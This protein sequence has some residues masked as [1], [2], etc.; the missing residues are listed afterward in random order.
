LLFFCFFLAIPLASANPISI[1]VEGQHF[2]ALSYIPLAILLVALAELVI[3][4]IRK[5]VT[6]RR[7]LYISLLSI[8]TADFLFFYTKALFLPSFISLKDPNY[9]YFLALNYGV[10]YV[11]PMLILSIATVDLG[12]YWLRRK[13][14]LTHKSLS[15]S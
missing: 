15:S 8:L 12:I 6:K 3:Y 9:F 1:E 5:K 14:N 13:N 4:T 10:Y 7:L 11:I 2:L